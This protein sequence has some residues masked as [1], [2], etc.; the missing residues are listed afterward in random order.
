MISRCW[1]CVLASTFLLIGV[2]VPAKAEER[3]EH[4]DQDPGWEGRNHLA[5][6]KTA[7]LIRQDFGYR[8]NGTANGNGGVGGFVTAA[9]EPA[10]YA[11]K[12]SAKSFNDVL[13][14]SGT[15]ACDDGRF[16]VLLGFFNANTLNEWRTPNT[17]AL[18]LSGRG[19][20]F[21]AWL[22]TPQ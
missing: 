18:R 13:S 2:S 4:F 1:Q 16:H 15:L 17:I 10:Y 21:Y 9:A 19:N 22:N 6:A 20:S 8:R 7:R 14:A 5:G 12:L 3:T 11:K